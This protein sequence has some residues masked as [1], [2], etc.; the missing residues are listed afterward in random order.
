[1]K[2]LASQRKDTLPK[3]AVFVDL[4]YWLLATTKHW[5]RSTPTTRSTR[6]TLRSYSKQ[7]TKSKQFSFLISNSTENAIFSISQLK[8]S[9]QNSS[10]NLK[11]KVQVINVYMQL[12]SIPNVT[13]CTVKAQL[14]YMKIIKK[15]HLGGRGKQFNNFQWFCK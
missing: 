15:M 9:E 5:S 7:E 10:T 6:L 13:L 11:T 8:Y 4:H 3:F 12:I 14:Y 2:E 1:M